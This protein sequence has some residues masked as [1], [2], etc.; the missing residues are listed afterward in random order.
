MTWRLL[1]NVSVLTLKKRGKK[2][3]KEEVAIARVSKIDHTIMLMGFAFI[4][5]FKNEVGSTIL[6][7]D[8][9]SSSFNSHKALF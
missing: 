8:F 1:G 2:N 4:S 3:K 5:L 9:L 6:S 7:F